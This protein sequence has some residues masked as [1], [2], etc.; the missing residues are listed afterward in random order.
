MK[1]QIES[2]GLVII[3]VLV[4]VLFLFALVFMTKKDVEGNSSLSVKADN[5]MNAV[6]KL[7]IDG[8][9]IEEQVSE[10]CEGNCDAFSQ[11]IRDIIEKSIEESYGFKVSKEGD[12]CKEIEA[13]DLGIAS[14]VYRLRNQE[15]K[16][17]LQVVLC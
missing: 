16:Y 2:V 7:R 1:G 11:N 9:S 5:L 12:V 3:V 8:R 15:E 6:T 14:S 10:C 13:C 17:E 4:I